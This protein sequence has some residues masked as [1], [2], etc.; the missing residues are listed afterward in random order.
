MI[1]VGLSIILMTTSLDAFDSINKPVKLQLSP[2]Q[3][4]Y[5]ADETAINGLRQQMLDGWNRGNGAAF[6]EA[7]TED[8]EFVGFNGIRLRGRQEIGANVQQLFD[9]VMN[10][11][12]L[13]GQVKNLR[14]LSSDVA[15]LNSVG[16]HLMPGEPRVLPGREFNQTMVAVKREGQW[17]IAAFHNSRVWKIEQQQLLEEYESLPIDAKREIA[18]LIKS[19]KQLRQSA[20][21]QASMP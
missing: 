5:A 7:F 4:S 14:F 8:G 2:R 13:T 16:G 6:A 21:I 17:R 3:V 20:N 1:P 18:E 15:V 12:R 9:G 10:G 19:Q 11:S